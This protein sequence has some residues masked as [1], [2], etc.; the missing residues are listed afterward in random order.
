MKRAFSAALLLSPALAF[1]HAGVDGGAHHGSAFIEGLTHPFNGFD[2]LAA[3]IAV[4]IWSAL[5]FRNSATG[6]WA[7]PMV[8][9]SLVLIGGLLAFG[10]LNLAGVEPMIAVSLLVLGVMVATQMKLPAAVGAT[11]VGAFALFHGVAHGS[12]LP[13]QQAFATLSGMVL[14][15]MS[16][17][18]VGMLLGRFVLERNVWLPRLA[19]AS[20]AVLGIGLLSGAI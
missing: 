14:A 9:A 3:M 11:L 10:G 2:H 17:H 7:V 19:G 1:A 16:L 12:E 15:T 20:V 8:F 4:G 5:A 13:A 18:I 6:M